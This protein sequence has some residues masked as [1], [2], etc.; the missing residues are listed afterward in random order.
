MN[1]NFGRRNLEF[2]YLTGNIRTNTGS[3]DINFLPLAASLCF[4]WQMSGWA[5][6]MALSGQV[7]VQSP[8]V[9]VGRVT[10]KN[11]VHASG[12]ISRDRKITKSRNPLLCPIAY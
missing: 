4:N 5:K 12:T 6:E 1:L 7:P 9:L 11:A 10:L 3:D 2:G 8:S